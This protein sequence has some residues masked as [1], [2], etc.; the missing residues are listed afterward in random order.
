MG[1]SVR[2]HSRAWSTAWLGLF[3]A[4]GGV[5]PQ[6]WWGTVRAC[7][8]ASFRCENFRFHPV[9]FGSFVTVWGLSSL[10]WA[11]QFFPR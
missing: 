11:V 9:V 6:V 2:V 7:E 1:E 8:V 10:L 4:G 3:S 5:H